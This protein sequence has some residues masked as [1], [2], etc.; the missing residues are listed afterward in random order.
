MS[1]DQREEGDRGV[2]G[3][4]SDAFDDWRWLPVWGG[5]G[6]VDLELARGLAPSGLPC[7]H[8]DFF[9]GFSLECER[10]KLVVV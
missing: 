9:G 3:V 1:G 7:G 4:S 2:P 5:E 6:K 8:G 10:V